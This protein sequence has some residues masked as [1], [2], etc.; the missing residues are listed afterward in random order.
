MTVQRDY[1]S[2]P[3]LWKRDESAPRQ[4]AFRARTRDEW[5]YWRE[6]LYNRLTELVGGFPV[7][8]PPLEASV[9]ETEDTPDFRLEKVAFQSEPGLYV[10]CYVLKPRHAQP[11]YRPVIA[12]HGHGSGGVSHLIG[13][14]QNEA[15]RDEEEASI[16]AYNYD[17]AAQLARHGF[18]VFAP[19]LRGFGERLET[20]P[21]MVTRMAGDPVWY[22]NSCRALFFNA[23]LLGKTVVGLRVWDVMRTIDYVRCRAEPMVQGLGCMG[24]SGGGMITLYAA[25][26]DARITVAIISGYFGSF[27]TS[28]MPVIHCECNYVP[29]LLRYAEMADIASL[30]AP[31]PLLIENGTE[32]PIFP[33]EA[34]ESAWEELRRVYELLGV[35]ERLEKDIFPGGHRFSGNKAF[36]WL[37]RWL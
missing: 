22:A 20:W 9:L 19:E 35:P 10:P 27:R 14:I 33:V 32:D 34:A 6:A 1:T 5:A 7:D 12:L 24:L 17:Y 15:L 29:G 8:R 28:I 26:L 30:I 3:S 25:A 13:R 16:R 11:P 23:V 31:R 36:A 37:D 21:N 2:L 4:L 18:L